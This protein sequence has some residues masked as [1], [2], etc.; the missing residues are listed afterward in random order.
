M[1]TTA[2]LASHKTET[3][4]VHGKNWA[5]WLRH[6]AGKADATGFEIGTFRGESAEWFLENIV[7][8]SDSRF[9]CIDPFTGNIEHQMGK[10]DCSTLESDTI[11]RLDR[12][13]N[14]TIVKDYSQN[15]LPKWIAE[16]RKFDFC[17]VDGSHDAA[18][19]L[20]DSVLSFE[21]L[22]TGGVL[23]WDDYLW[24]VMDGESNRPKIAIDGFV[25]SYSPKLRI[26]EIGWQ[27]CIVKKT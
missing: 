21:L 9:F 4:R 13:K 18:S 8:H 25:K 19:V 1:N 17:Y 5:K 6:M 3:G 22:K 2:S 16:G 27:F 23:I 12:F 7:T 10:T 20:R 15:I 11:K 26:E 24:E 14:V